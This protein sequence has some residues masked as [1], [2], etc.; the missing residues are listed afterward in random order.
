MRWLEY[1]IMTLNIMNCVSYASYLPIFMICSRFFSIICLHFTHSFTFGVC[2][3]GP[4]AIS[5]FLPNI[6]K[7]YAEFSH[8]TKVKNKLRN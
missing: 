2:V 6:L 4:I 5:L 1:K 8:A 7:E 3:C